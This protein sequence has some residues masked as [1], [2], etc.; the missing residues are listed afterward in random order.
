MMLQLGL[1]ANFRHQI[2]EWDDT[3]IPMKDPVNFIGQLDLTKS[4]IREV[5]KQTAEQASTR[6][7]TERVVKIINSTHT[8]AY[9]DN[10]DAE[11]V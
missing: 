7:T 8:K 9:F 10:V 4:E 5:V 3:V 11:E 6:E 1:K 2:L